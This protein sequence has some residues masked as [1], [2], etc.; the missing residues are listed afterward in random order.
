M[1]FDVPYIVIIRYIGSNLISWILH[2]LFASL[3]PR[4][5][6]PVYRP[7]PKCQL[8]ANLCDMR[9]MHTHFAI[10]YVGSQC[11]S[12]RFVRLLRSR[13]IGDI[14]SMMHMLF[15]LSLSVGFSMKIYCFKL[16]DK[17]FAHESLFSIFVRGTFLEES[18]FRGL[19]DQRHNPLVRDDL[20]GGVTLPLLQFRV[21]G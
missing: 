5:L 14:P 9:I 18:I 12:G 21:G 20:D 17:S 4:S 11:I 3:I 1:V 16:F 8:L 2:R 10:L 6:I 19:L 7:F 15:S 13:Q